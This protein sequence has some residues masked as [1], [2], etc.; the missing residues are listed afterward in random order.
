MK[1]KLTKPITNLLAFATVLLLPVAL[2]AQQIA[3]PEISGTATPSASGN[4]QSEIRNPQ[5]SAEDEP[6]VLDIFNVTGTN[7]NEWVSTQSLTGARM[8]EEITNLPYQMQIVTA[9]FIQDFAFTSI[10]EQ[11]SAVSGMSLQA[12]VADP[13]AAGSA[14]FRGSGSRLRGFPAV[15]IRDGF[16]MT[17]PPQPI[18][19]KQIEVLKGPGACALYGS[20]EPGGI[21][22]YISERP[23]AKP[24]LKGILRLGNYSTWETSVEANTPLVPGKLFFLGAASITSRDGNN[25]YAFNRTATYIGS[26]LYRPWQNTNITVTWESQKAEGRRNENAPSLQVN[27]TPS[28]SLGG[29]VRTSGTVTGVYWDWL[30][31]GLNYAGPNQY[32]WRNYDRLHIQIEH[33]FNRN[34][35]FRL[36]YQWQY[37]TFD[38]NEY[39]TYSPFTYNVSTSMIVNK[40]PQVRDQVWDMPY[41]FIADLIGT[42]KTG[43]IRHA[44]LICADTTRWLDQDGYWRLANSGPYNTAIPNEIYYFNPWLNLDPNSSGW[45]TDWFSWDQMRSK[46]RGPNRND[47]P[48]RLGS[49]AYLNI[50]FRGAS[51][52]DRMFMFNDRLILHGVL[53][54]DK[55]KYDRYGA[56]ALQPLKSDPDFNPDDVMYTSR[57]QTTYTLGANWRILPG[58]NL[59]LFANY[60]TSFNGQAI[61]D[62]GR[63]ELMPNE[64]GKGAEIGVKIIPNR[65]FALV[66]SAYWIKKYNILTDNKAYDLDNLSGEPQYTYGTHRAYG[67]DADFTWSPTRNLTIKGGVNYIDTTIVDSGYDVLIGQRRLQVPNKDV[68]IFVRYNCPGALKGLAL[69]ASVRYY[70]S[71]LRMHYTPATN[72]TPEYLS[73]TIGGAATWNAYIQYRWRV[74]RVLHTFQL[75]GNNIFNKFHISGSTLNFGAR[76]NA[77]YT[78]HFR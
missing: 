58:D 11:L 69:G 40:I 3:Q 62:R 57:G 65:N 42:F 64:N 39:Y 75:N 18:N 29:W 36:A 12:D 14:S 68:N 74:R 67:A 17:Q 55:N 7:D 38:D 49:R 51:I 4:P 1:T 27:T 2:A 19:T 71:W 10:V 26:V 24:F 23:T 54:F 15:I 59:V 50:L 78:V 35:S 60:C 48:A 66:A 41:A 56:S 52:S 77:T 47:G 8:A 20:A 72:T 31:A 5:S 63:N 13:G 34:W 21:I 43:K 37:K 45:R 73:E 6:I 53:R 22:N 9:E 70:G 44:L 16:R 30:R 32:Y 46:D 61:V 76:F 33:R 25:I 28:G